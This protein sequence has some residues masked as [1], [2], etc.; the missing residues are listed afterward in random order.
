MSK[1]TTIDSKE[2]KQPDVFQKKGL[3][4]LGSLL[5]KRERLLPIAIGAV[6]IVLIAV[7][8]DYFSSAGEEKAWKQYQDAT[9]APEEQK[10]TA[11]KSLAGSSSSRAGFLAA[12]MI[13]DHLYEEARKDFGKN[14]AVVKAKGQEAI[15]WYSKTIKWGGL[16]AT[17][18]QLLLVN[19]GGS[20]E[21][22]SQW[23]EAKK[24]YEEA[25]QI[26][27]FAKGWALLNLGNVY[28]QEGDKNKAI[29]TYQKVVSN[30]PESSY[31][32]TAKHFLRR[33]KSPLFTEV[34]GK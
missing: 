32:K 9:K 8:W 11:L 30:D 5:S 33:L 21:L 14:E 3:A 24:D 26:D 2:L 19:R 10:W 4:L 25:S 20:Y 15:D 29:E 34:E 17:E 28:E 13:A 18:K 6:A 23:P 22:L 12:T 31:A 1:D 16:A 7:G 27:G